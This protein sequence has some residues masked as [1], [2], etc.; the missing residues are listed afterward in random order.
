MVYHSL[1]LCCMDKKGCESLWQGSG[2]DGL[3]SAPGYTS[4]QLHNLL[5]HSTCSSCPFLYRVLAQVLSVTV[6]E[7]NQRPQNG[8]LT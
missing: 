2:G 5:E 1:F 7:T 6:E 4:H 8:T 3:L